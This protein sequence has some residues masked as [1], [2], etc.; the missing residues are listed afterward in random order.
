MPMWSTPPGAVAVEDPVMET[1]GIAK[2]EKV[3]GSTAEVVIERQEACAHCHSAD[4]CNAL[5][6]RGTL[7]IE[8]DNPVGAQAGQVVELVSASSGGLKAAFM[9]YMLPA[10]LFV[11]GVIVGAQALHWSPLGSGLLGLGALAAA[12]FVAWLY[13]RRARTD[14]EF[15][16]VISRVVG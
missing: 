2:V 8:A 5:A 12:W 11:T 9:V 4:L 10:I 15:R 3:H 16:V 14:R 6:G 7:R 13:D 1:C